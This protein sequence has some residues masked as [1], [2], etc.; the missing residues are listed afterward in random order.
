MLRTFYLQLFA[1]LVLVPTGHCQTTNTVINDPTVAKLANPIPSVSVGDK[2]SVRL[3]A[4][5]CY[6]CQ[7]FANAGVTETSNVYF[8]QI[9]TN[10]SEPDGFVSE[11]RGST[12][13]SLDG[14]ASDQSRVCFSVT[15][16][17]RAVSVTMTP[18]ISPVVAS[19]SNVRV[20]CEETTLY[21]GYNTN[22]TELNFLEITNVLGGSGSVSDEEERVTVSVRGFDAQTRE[23]TVDSSF[24]LGGQ[25]RRDLALHD[26][27][28]ANNFGLL[29][30]C[31]DA[32]RGAIQ[33]NVSRYNITSSDPLDFDLVTT[34]PLSP[35]DGG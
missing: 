24:V 11:F 6:C 3:Q 1:L 12:F 7:V 28:G 29:Q 32:P 4:N 9:E 35:R 15:D 22:A 20:A 23:Q 10:P 19:V 13:P 16:S 33:A 18:G 30:I 5:R 25:S 2:V 14:N 27:V 34:E 21:G 8:S 26:L 17:N 31:H